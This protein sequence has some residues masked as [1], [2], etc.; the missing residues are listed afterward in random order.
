M[1]SNVMGNATLTIEPKSSTARVNHFGRLTVR[2]W[3]A[4]RSLHTLFVTHFGFKFCIVSTEK[5][6]VFTKSLSLGLP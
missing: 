2:A 1:T 5:S 4:W 3:R 6:V